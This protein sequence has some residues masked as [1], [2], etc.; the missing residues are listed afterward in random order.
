MRI[1]IILAGAIFIGGLGFA[2][3]QPAEADL[4]SILNNQPAPPP[5]RA[6]VKAPKA[7][8]APSKSAKVQKAAKPAP[9]A[10]KSRKKSRKKNSKKKRSLG[11][12]GE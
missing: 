7:K 11:D 10:K 3:P 4:L 1:K 6:R 12:L 2:L 8:A 5:K 9:A